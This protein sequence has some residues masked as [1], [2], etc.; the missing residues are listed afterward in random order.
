VLFGNEVGLLEEA[1][2]FGCV[3]GCVGGRKTEDED[4]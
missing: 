3:D 1:E 4:D 2:G